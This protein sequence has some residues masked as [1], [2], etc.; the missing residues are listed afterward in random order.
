MIMLVTSGVRMIPSAVAL[1]QTDGF[2]AE[3]AA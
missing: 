1:H 3:S 2:T